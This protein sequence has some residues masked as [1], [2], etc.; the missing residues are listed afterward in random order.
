MTTEDLKLIDESLVNHG[1]DFWNDPNNDGE[2]DNPNRGWIILEILS[3]LA[4][5]G[6]DLK[7]IPKV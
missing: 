1:D 6:F 4:Q 7:V 3:I 5:D 2:Q